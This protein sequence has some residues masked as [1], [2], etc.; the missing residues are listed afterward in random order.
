M[1][2]YKVYESAVLPY[3]LQPPGGY[4]GFSYNDT[5]L[6]G[7]YLDSVYLGVGHVHAVWAARKD[8]NETPNS[9]TTVYILYTVATAS[10]PS[11][12]I[13][14]AAFDGQTGQ[15]EWF[16][17]ETYWLNAVG[18]AIRDNYWQ[19]T[20]DL[21]WSHHMWGYSMRH[22]VRTENENNFAGGIGM[23][24]Y[25]T[26][27]IQIYDN[28]WLDPNGD[29]YTGGD[30]VVL[31]MLAILPKENRA[32]MIRAGDRSALII[33][34]Y[35]TKKE[36]F[37]I[38]VTRSIA[39]GIAV[40]NEIFYCVSSGGIIDVINYKTGQHGG[41]LSLGDKFTASAWMGL[42]YDPV[43]RRMLTFTPKPDDPGT[44]KCTS[45]IEGFRMLEV[46]EYLVKPIALKAPRKDRVVPVYSRVVSDSAKGVPGL[47]VQSSVTGANALDPEFVTTD[48]VG[49]VRFHWDTAVVGVDIDQIDLS[50]SYETEV[51]GL[52]PPA[53]NTV[54][55]TPPSNVANENLFTPGWWFYQPLS[56]LTPAAKWDA[57]M[58]GFTEEG[59]MPIIGVL[60]E[61]KWTDFETDTPATFDWSK[62]TDDLAY[63][64]NLGV[65][66]IISLVLTSES[67]TDI[68]IP[69]DI[70]EDVSQP[71]SQIYPQSLDPISFLEGRGI[72][73]LGNTNTSGEGFCPILWDENVHARVR[74]LFSSM[75][76]EFGGDNDV[77]GYALGDNRSSSIDITN[78]SLVLP[79][80]YFE[81]RL[82]L[83]DYINGLTS[84]LIWEFG[85][86]NSWS[87]LSNAV[88][89]GIN[90]APAALYQDDKLPFDPRYA[91]MLS[92]SDAVSYGYVVDEDA[93]NRAENLLC[94][95]GTPETNAFEKAFG[96]PDIDFC[97]MDYMDRYRPYFVFWYPDAAKWS[98]TDGIL[99]VCQDYQLSRARAYWG[100]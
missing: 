28:E 100:I 37:R 20:D 81:A 11:W 59:E 21:S 44:G 31:E 46:P 71:P 83:L 27:D 89:A 1:S 79:E 56:D 4:T 25:M 16:D 61:Y 35:T 57:F 67:D 9:H 24:S 26:W 18:M 49:E 72:F 99:E 23:P 52:S 78:T 95:A 93:D 53:A 66:L 77:V 75:N 7:D 36:L 29:A 98:G 3:R 73:H 40:D 90:I 85:T 97:G 5:I 76:V 82:R 32:M 54:K 70:L 94:T 69:D 58:T 17:S 88:Q 65:K 60:Q 38:K 74:G 30:A 19:D 47:S 10:W 8:I 50:V 34:D 84:K 63:L 51:A 13:H 87:H 62:I 55:G 64:S 80:T 86:R 92:D 14:M 39:K 22:P 6:A 15:Q 45:F 2:L 12:R 96:G 41:I 68:W 91:L 42:G 48:V 33:S 43:Y